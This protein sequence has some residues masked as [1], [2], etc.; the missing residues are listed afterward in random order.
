[1][2]Y[3]ILDRTVYSNNTKSLESP[4]VSLFFSGHCYMHMCIYTNTFKAIFNTMRWDDTVHCT[5]HVHR[6]L[7]WASHIRYIHYICEASI[8]R[9]YSIQNLQIQMQWNI[10]MQRAKVNGLNGSSRFSYISNMSLLRFVCK[11]NTSSVLLRCLGEL[12]GPVRFVTR[13]G[14]LMIVMST[15]KKN[16]QNKRRTPRDHSRFTTH[17]YTNTYFTPNLNWQTVSMWKVVLKPP[18]DFVSFDGF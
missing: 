1:M 8:K 16:E 9:N 13:F 18:F 11:L 7:V 10:E 15:Q 5:H 17:T 6:Y 12:L 4:L 14:C 3:F 2:L